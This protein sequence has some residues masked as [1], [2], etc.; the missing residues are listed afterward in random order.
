MVNAKPQ[1]PPALPAWMLNL[2]A[3]D[4]RMQNLGYAEMDQYQNGGIPPM[5]GQGERIL[6]DGVS[7]N[8]FASRSFFPQE[9]LA[10]MSSQGMGTYTAPTTGDRI[11]RAAQGFFKGFDTGNTAGNVGLQ[12]GASFVPGGQMANSVAGAVQGAR[13][14]QPDFDKFKTPRPGLTEDLTNGDMHRGWDQSFGENQ[15][16]L[17]LLQMQQPNEVNSQGPYGPDGAVN[18]PPAGLPGAG[19]AGAAGAPQ[20]TTAPAALAPSQFTGGSGSPVDPYALPPEA[21]IE[22]LLANAQRYGGYDAATG[23]IG[24]AGAGGGNYSYSGFDFGQDA[25]NRDVGKSAKYAFSHLAGQ[26]AAAGAPQPMDKAG[27]EAWFNQ[28]IAPGLQQLGYEIGWVKGDK[29]R[30]KTREGWDEIDFLGNAGGDNPSLTWQSEVLAPGGG[31]SAG[32]GGGGGLTPTSGDQSSSAL[33]EQLM[34]QARMIAEGQMTGASPTDTNA[35]LAL[36][37]GS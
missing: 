16:L 3:Q 29:A 13:S 15:A 24:A 5:G 27:A 37:G 11:G 20:Q 23:R 17:S 26:A 7:Q 33:F 35:L 28:Y 4:A 8:D 1:P 22:A 9:G 34:K 18:P 32:A 31:M 2:D 14:D 25:G 21:D 19:S 6:N 10:G 30:I 36:L 12:V